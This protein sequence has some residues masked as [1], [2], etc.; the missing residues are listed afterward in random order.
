MAKIHL[1]SQ[2]SNHFHVR[3]F[4]SITSADYSYLFQTSVIIPVLAGVQVYENSGFLKMS[5]NQLHPLAQ[6]LIIFS[7]CVAVII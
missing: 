4:G 2:V 6:L 5:S 3:T 7:V 1:L